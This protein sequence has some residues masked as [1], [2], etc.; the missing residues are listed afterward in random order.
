MPVV[1]DDQKVLLRTHPHTSLHYLAVLKPASIVSARYGGG[2]NTGAVFTALVDSVTV[3]AD[4]ASITEITYKNSAGQWQDADQHFTLWVGTAAGLQDKGRVRLRKNS[5]ATKLYPAECNHIDFQVDDHLTVYP[6]VEPTVRYRRQRWNP[7]P[8]ETLDLWIDWDIAY[9]DQNE[10]LYPVAMMG[11][12]AAADLVAGTATVAFDGSASYGMAGA[13]IADGDHDWVFPGGTPATFSGKTPGNV[14]WDAAGQYLCSLT[15][16]DSNGKST[17]TYRIVFVDYST[18]Y[19]YFE[20][21]GLSASLNS[22]GWRSDFDVFGDAD[23]DEFP[24]GTMVALVTQEWYGTT[25]RDFGGNHAGRHN[26]RYVGW[27]QKDTTTKDPET[28]T[29]RFETLGITGVI[30]Q[31]ENFSIYLEDN[32][33][34]PTTWYGLKDLSVQKALHHYLYWHTTLF[35]CTDVDVSSA[36]TDLLYEQSFALAS[37]PKALDQFLKQAHCWWGADRT[38]C[39][40][41]QKDPDLLAAPDDDPD[42]R[43]AVPTTMILEHQDWVGQLELPIEQVEKCSFLYVDG[44]YYTGGADQDNVDYYIAYAPGRSPGY[45]GGRNQ[46]KGVNVPATQEGVNKLAGLLRAQ[47]NN[48]MPRI[49]MLLAGN[50]AVFD[51]APVHWTKMS[52]AAGDTRRGLVWTNQRLLPR[53]IAETLN[54]EAGSIDV[55]IEFSKEAYGPA[56]VTGDYPSDEEPE[57]PYDP[58]P[59]P[60][61]PPEPTPGEWDG[62]IYCATNKGVARCDDITATP[63]VWTAINTGLS[64]DALDVY[65][66]AIVNQTDE[67]VIVTK[68]GV[69]LGTNIST[70]AASWTRILSVAE[71]SALAG[72]AVAFCTSWGYNTAALHLADHPVMSWYL[73]PGYVGVFVQRDD[74]AAYDAFTKYYLHTHDYGVDGWVS[75]GSL[76]AQLGADWNEGMAGIQAC[77]YSWE[78]TGRLHLI[79]GNP[80]GAGSYRYVYST[81]Y[82]TNG[83]WN[84]GNTLNFSAAGPGGTT[85]EQTPYKPDES[86]NTNDQFVVGTDYQEPPGVGAVKRTLTGWN[87][88]TWTSIGAAG[89]VGIGMV[90][91]HPFHPNYMIVACDTGGGASEAVFTT[92]DGGTTWSNPWSP[93]DLYNIARMAR[94]P[95]DVNDWIFGMSR[96]Y[97][98]RFV[99]YTDDFLATSPPADKT[100]NL[101]TVLAGMTCVTELRTTY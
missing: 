101:A 64:G 14:T 50:Y 7:G 81:D 75:S 65:G 67:A 37:V 54:N 19:E 51:I 69:Y 9:T 98:S 13:T 42:P 60:T 63:A 36:P 73:D 57:P 53:Q 72:I 97:A 11:P 91:V 77:H 68:A 3:D 89:M 43:N 30:D 16:V 18:F 100:G 22:H 33:G 76:A 86:W 70:A 83:T 59:A 10:D 94:N 58:P 28:S 82:G 34:A 8:P 46:L 44:M 87:T 29:V 55:R 17:T 80:K 78:T 71:A 61:P 88:A 23:I 96:E 41:F 32:A 92:P 49:P 26:I 79:C 99:F 47:I 12:T 6:Y 38:S 5:N 93:T 66:M 24:D 85:A 1:T 90:R 35:F 27:I 25:L 15:V 31:R 20:I 21:G 74:G 40:Y 52:I 2:T 95:H 62:I 48:P 84:P 45:F 39:I 56:G 4:T